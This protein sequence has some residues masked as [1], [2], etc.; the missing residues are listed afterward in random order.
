[1]VDLLLTRAQ[2]NGSLRPDV[3]AMDLLMLFKGACA[4]AAAFAHTDSAAID[5]QLNGIHQIIQMNERLPVRSAARVEV[6]RELALVDA[7]N[8]VRQRDRVA[9]VAIHSSDAQQRC[10][11]ITVLLPNKLLGA[12]FRLWVRPCWP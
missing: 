12:N 6:A 7:L 1:M 11:D 4:A 10:R 5:R 8:L 3:G 9:A 2:E